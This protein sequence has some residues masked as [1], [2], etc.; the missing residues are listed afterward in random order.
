MEKS[1]HTK[2]QK[3]KY[4]IHND[5]HPL[6]GPSILIDSVLEEGFQ[7]ALDWSRGLDSQSLNLEND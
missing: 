5:H 6:G 4:P 1:L 2:V 7:W 3:G